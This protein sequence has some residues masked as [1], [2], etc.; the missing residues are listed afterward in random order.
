MDRHNI[1]VGRLAMWCNLGEGGV[2]RYKSL[3]YGD[4]LVGGGG[5]T[6]RGDHLVSWHPVSEFLYSPSGMRTT[7]CNERKVR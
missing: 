1:S 6:F 2:S 7:L 5:G 3:Q 4:V